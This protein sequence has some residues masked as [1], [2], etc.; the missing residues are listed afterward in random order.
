MIGGVE[1]EKKKEY[2]VWLVAVICISLG[3]LYA[4]EWFKANERN[5]KTNT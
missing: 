5:K 1:N 3:T 4:N 2:C